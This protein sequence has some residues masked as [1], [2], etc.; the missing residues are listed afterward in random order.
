MSKGSI[1]STTPHPTRVML[2]YFLKSPRLRTA[3]GRSYNVSTI[4]SR[5]RTPQSFIT[6]IP[7]RSRYPFW[8]AKEHSNCHW[9]TSLPRS[10]GIYWPTCQSLRIYHREYKT[11]PKSGEFPKE[12]HYY[13]RCRFRVCSGSNSVICKC[14]EHPLYYCP[15]FKSMSHDCKLFLVIVCA[16][17]VWNLGIF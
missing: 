11:S 14:E 6:S 10:V 16:W 4:L 17:I 12:D 3:V 15:K 1:R 13:V 2:K 9:C 5:I 8:M 7:I